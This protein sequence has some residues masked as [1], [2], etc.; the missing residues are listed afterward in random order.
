MPLLAALRNDEF[1]ATISAQGEPLLQHLEVCLGQ[2]MLNHDGRRDD[3]CLGIELTDEAIEDLARL[4][5][6][7]RPHRKELGPQDFS[8]AKES[9]LHAG[10]TASPLGDRDDVGIRATRAH[11]FLAL[12]H[13]LDRADSI[14]EL[15]SAL[16]VPR[17]GRL[18]HFL[19]E[20]PNDLVGLPVEEKCGLGDRSHVGVAINGGDAGRQ[21][22]MEVVVQADLIVAGDLDV[23]LAIRKQTIEQIQ[24]AVGGPRGGVRA[25][26]LAAVV[27]DTA[28]Q[29]HPW[30][31]L[32]GDAE[33]RVG[34][35][36]LEQNVV[37]RL[38]TLDELVLED[39]GFRRSVGPDDL[40]IH[41]VGDEFPRLGVK[42][43]RVLE[44]TAQAISQLGGLADIQD[45][46]G[47]AFHEIATRRGGERAQ[48]VAEIRSL[49]GLHTGSIGGV[50]WR[51]L[52]PGS[53]CRP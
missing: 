12:D 1:N 46:A 8:I 2:C 42:R 5:V 24:R 23:A 28:S 37:L 22:L 19:F 38:V 40:E 51:P 21:A 6:D 32:I 50:S 15:G 4:I 44:V 17:V 35:A 41:D 14:A 26:V 16:K 34:L 29:L 27:D 47:L 7:A 45:V 10:I 3:R 20:W 33:V 25:E 39:Q 52:R 53:R 13:V 9:D 11:H 18:G 36:V 49:C 30:P 31:F 48:S 43:A